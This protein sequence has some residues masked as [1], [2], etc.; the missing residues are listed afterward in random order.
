MSLLLSRRVRSQ[1]KACDWICYCYAGRFPFKPKRGS[2]HPPTQAGRGIRNSRARDLPQF[3]ALPSVETGSNLGTSPASPF[4]S[5]AH[6]E[7]HII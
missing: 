2:S 6:P 4:V 5:A 1:Q 3:F 7:T